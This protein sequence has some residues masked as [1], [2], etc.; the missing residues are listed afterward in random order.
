MAFAEIATDLLV[1]L[2]SGV[3]DLAFKGYSSTDHLH[4][5]LSGISAKE[6]LGRWVR[7]PPGLGAFSGGGV[8]FRYDA[9]ADTL[10]SSLTLDESVLVNRGLFVALLATW[11]GTRV[12]VEDFATKATSLTVRVS[13][14]LGLSVRESG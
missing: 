6:F 14:E 7:D 11:D 1:A 2:R 9:Q 10:W 13:E 4:G 12:S 8:L 5:T 3:P